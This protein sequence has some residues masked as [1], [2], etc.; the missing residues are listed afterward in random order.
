MYYGLMIHTCSLL[1]LSQ[2][3]SPDMLTHRLTLV[4]PSV[5]I[6]CATWLDDGFVLI[7][8]SVLLSVSATWDMY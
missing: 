5:T 4:D 2:S 3:M 7:V 6:N 1:T 8:A